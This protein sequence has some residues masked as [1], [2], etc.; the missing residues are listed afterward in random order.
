MSLILLRPLS[1]MPPNSA[2]CYTQTSTALVASLVAGRSLYF[3]ILNNPEKSR[4][5]GYKTREFH[6]L[7]AIEMDLNLRLTQCKLQSLSIQT[8][9]YYL[10]GVDEGG[11]FGV[12][13]V[14]P[15]VLCLPRLFSI[16]PSPFNE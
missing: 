16:L 3:L 5:S 7:Q 15:T 9:Y 11:V 12:W 1:Q 13:S 10:M 4:N 14:G 6:I 8:Y 2:V